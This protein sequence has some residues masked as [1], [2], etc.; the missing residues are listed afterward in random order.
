[1]AKAPGSLFY[2]CLKVNC[3]SF[4]ADACE[5]SDEIVSMEKVPSTC[6]ESMP[7]LVQEPIGSFEY[8]VLGWEF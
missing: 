4:C 5:E 8:W 7:L 6:S 2:W 1:M 3:F